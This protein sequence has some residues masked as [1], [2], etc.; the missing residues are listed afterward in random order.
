MLL[1]FMTERKTRTPLFE[2]PFRMAET[3]AIVCRMQPNARRDQADLIPGVIR[4]H[5]VIRD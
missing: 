2:N 1:R 5:R 4:I 3:F